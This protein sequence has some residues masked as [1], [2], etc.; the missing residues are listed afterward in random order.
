MQVG[1]LGP[2]E[3]RIAGDLLDVPGRRLRV[4]LGRLAADVP[5]PVAAD[6]LIEVLWPGTAPADPSNSLQSLVSR[7]R[8]AVGD[9][10]LVVQTPGGY[11][12][13]V[14]PEDVD[15]VRFARLADRG[16]AELVA[17]AP[18]A[19]ADTLREALG[20]WRGEPLPDDESSGALSLRHRLAEQ[21]GRAVLD[22]LTA[23]LEL[24]RAP[25]AGVLGEVEGLLAQE[26]LRED[27]VL[28]KLRALVAAGRP[29]DALAA[30]EDT[31]RRLVDELGADPSPQLRALHAELLAGPTDVER[32]RSNLRATVTS[33][34][35]RQSDVARLEDL[36]GAGRLV[37]VVGPGGAGKTRVATEEP[38]PT[39][40]RA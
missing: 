39:A 10:A 24:G 20:C 19:A 16:H 8:R 31:R 35:G 25:A 40:S 5:R 21:H 12:L 4:L 2:L 17:G 9:P 26:P 37:T 13:V 33:F 36:L 11:R 38:R 18:V 34:V 27:L 23:E 14:E 7:L 3:V 28:I 15:A 32:R 22:R 30:Y 29:A 1:F 6:V